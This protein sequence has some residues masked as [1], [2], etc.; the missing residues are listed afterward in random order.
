M[1]PALAR[2]WIAT[3]RGEVVDAEPLRSTQGAVWRVTV[4]REARVLVKQ[5]SGAA[6][7]RECW[8]LE[9]ARATGSTPVLLS[10]PAKDL[11][12]LSWHEGVSSLASDAMRSAGAW[13][14]GLHGLGGAFEDPL[15][16][17]DAIGQR[18]DAWLSRAQPFLPEETR[19][20]LH[21]AIDPA[22]FAS[23]QRTACHRDFM[24]TNWLWSGAL[25]VI[26]FGQA[27]PD[28]PLWDLV[29]LEAETFHEHPELRSTFLDGYGPLDTQAE[30]QLGQLVLLHGLQTA[31][32]GDIH[33][34]AGF[35][36]LGRQVLERRLS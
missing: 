31:V 6:I 22:A 20:R 28:V 26:D 35:S 32:W 36:R 4:R 30:D 9:V 25:T 24:P 23:L 8:G 11:V 29:K 10:R 18:R 34:D 7:D 5:A 16:V 15:S 19:A 1:L 2:S 17:S 3:H 27:R 33:D 13:L 14:R 12:V 21:K